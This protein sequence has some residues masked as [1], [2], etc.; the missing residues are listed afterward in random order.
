ML[1]TF[2][3][4]H[5]HRIPVLIG[6]Y[7]FL[8]F[9]NTGKVRHIQKANGF[10]DIANPQGGIPKKLLCPFHPHMIQYFRKGLPCVFI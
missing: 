7:P 10:S 4:G 2:L 1:K 3:L 6:G 9:E 8:F 5:A